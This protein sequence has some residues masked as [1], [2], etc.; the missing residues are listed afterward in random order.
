MEE[1]GFGDV[2]C[3]G[4]EREGGVKDEAEVADLGGGGDVGAVDVEGEVL[5]GAGKRVRADDQDF[6]FIAVEFEKIGLHP[7][8]NVSEAGGEGGVGGLGD[9]SAGE[10]ELG[11][12]CVAVKTETMMAKDLTKGEDVQN[13][14]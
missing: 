2:V 5:D 3:V 14:K 1:S 11:I 10:V 4:K 7:G 6:G 13:E 12:I 9:G 8:F